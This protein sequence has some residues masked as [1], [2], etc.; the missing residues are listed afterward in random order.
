MQR[1]TCRLV[2]SEHH[3]P[4]MPPIRCVKLH[5]PRTGHG[6]ALPF[7][8]HFAKAPFDDGLAYTVRF[9]KLRYRLFSILITAPQHI[10]SHLFYVAEPESATL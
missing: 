5:E 2:L 6:W 9:R 7:Y 3:T 10:Q 8:C 1:K 4:V